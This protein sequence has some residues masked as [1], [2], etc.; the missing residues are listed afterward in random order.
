[1]YTAITGILLSLVLALFNVRVSV[2]EIWVCSQPNGSTL[3]TDA[4]QRERSC[5]KFEPGSQVIYLPPRIWA[6]PPSSEVAYEKQ[7]ATE[8]DPPPA[9]RIEEQAVV[10]FD[11]G[12]SYNAHPDDF[13]S[14]GKSPIFVYTYVSPFYGLPSA[15][16]MRPRA[17][18]GHPRTQHGIRQTIPLWHQSAPLTAPRHRRETSV[19]AGAQTAQPQ[20]VS[21]ASSSPHVRGGSAGTP[22]AVAPAPAPSS[23]FSPRMRR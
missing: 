12:E 9:R 13:W 4:P 16:H 14:W 21:P 1:M 20:S 6:D 15:R 22:A 3:Y 17:F 18:L 11:A 10:P 8:E 5:E 2:A 23:G 19:Q 7:E